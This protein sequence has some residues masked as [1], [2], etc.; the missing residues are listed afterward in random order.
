MENM[1]LDFASQKRG[2]AVFASIIRYQV[3]LK[4]LHWNKCADASKK[5]LCASPLCSVFSLHFFM[6]LTFFFSRSLS[7]DCR[8]FAAVH[9]AP[10]T[11]CMRDFHFFTHF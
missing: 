3:V 2:A 5:V 7:Q 1:K 10:H 11:T 4:I 9:F 6:N 8:R